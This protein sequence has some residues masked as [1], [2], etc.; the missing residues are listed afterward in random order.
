MEHRDIDI[1]ET[2]EVD[3][4]MKKIARELKSGLYSILVCGA[5][6]LVVVIMLFAQAYAILR[7]LYGTGI[8]ALYLM[9]SVSAL[10]LWIAL[11]YHR[12]A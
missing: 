8:W 3:I 11:R 1:A 5:M 12:G 2:S 9:I 4:F 7:A 6:C 10:F